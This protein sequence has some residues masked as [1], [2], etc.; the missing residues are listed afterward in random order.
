[1]SLWTFPTHQIPEGEA[2]ALLSAMQWAS[3]MFVYNIIVKMDCKSI[4]DNI[5]QAKI[6]H[7]EF[8]SIVLQCKQLL[9][10]LYNSRIEFVKKQANTI[11]HKLVRMVVFLT[12]SHVFSYILSCIGDIISTIES[13]PFKNK[14][15]NNA[16]L[17]QCINYLA[18]LIRCLDMLF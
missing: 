1:M 10:S 8:G 5:Q 4:V 16:L 12:S 11:A 6:E 9:S 18:N 14:N 2:L 13:V 3:T 15:K 7:T 17:F